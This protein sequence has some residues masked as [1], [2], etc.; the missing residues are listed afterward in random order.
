MNRTFILLRLLLFQISICT[1]FVTYFTIR[2]PAK[3]KRKVSY[4]KVSRV[5]TSCKRSR[6]TVSY[7]LQAHIFSSLFGIQKTTFGCIFINYE[8][9]RDPPFFHQNYDKKIIVYFYFFENVVNL[10][11]ILWYMYNGLRKYLCKQRFFSYLLTLPHSG[12]GVKF[13]NLAGNNLIEC[14][15]CDL[16]PPL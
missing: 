14:L 4:N 6:V 11:Y 5:L 8:G 16:L 9:K 1:I 12:K 3:I 13:K 2:V 15:R 7:L 10:F